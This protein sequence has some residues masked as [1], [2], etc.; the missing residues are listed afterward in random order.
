M[1]TKRK[2]KAKPPLEGDR[3]GK[4]QGSGC[5]VINAGRESSSIQGLPSFTGI[6]TETA[7]SQGICMQLVTI[8][9][10]SRAKAHR[11]ES[12]ETAIYVISGEVEVWYGQGL[13][14]QNVV[15]AGEFLYIP[16]STPH[17]P[18]N[19]SDAEPCVSVL[20][21]TDPNEQEGVVLMPELDELP[22]L[23]QKA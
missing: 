16:A 6:S 17:L 8:P 9:P 12:H 7:D 10:R 3:I 14:D 23:V 2:T 13:Q 5:V 18:I 15:R 4:G 11:H 22:N 19:W 20:A 21:R 1:T